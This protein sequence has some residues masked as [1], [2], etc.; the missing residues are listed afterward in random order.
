MFISALVTDVSFFNVPGVSPGKRP[1]SGVDTVS[2]KG[3]GLWNGHAGYTFAAIA[4]DAGEPG[5]GRDTFAITISDST[6]HVVA[7][8][9]ATITSGNIQSLRAF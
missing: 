5:P 9:N 2:F 7:S 8:L 3:I 6:G 1:A 4:V